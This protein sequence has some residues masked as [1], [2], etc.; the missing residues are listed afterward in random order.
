ML[1][2]SFSFLPYLVEKQGWRLLSDADVAKFL[3]SAQS[4][5]DRRK[6]L[7]MPLAEALQPQHGL[8]SQAAIVVRHDVPKV[9]L[10][11]S[12]SNQP[13]LVQRD[14]SESVI[15]ILSAFDLM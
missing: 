5:T 9:E 4:K 12:I 13:M 15:G 7:A 1:L 2:H 11:N 14:S 10:I 3:I 8:S 6:R